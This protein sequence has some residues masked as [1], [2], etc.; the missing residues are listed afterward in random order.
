MGAL[1]C[2]DCTHAS[3]LCIFGVLNCSL[4]LSL[5]PLRSR[6][7]PETTAAIVLTGAEGG[8]E[9]EAAVAVCK[10]AEITTVVRQSVQQEPT[11][12]LKDGRVRFGEEE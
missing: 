10:E 2:A 11:G 8:E 1:R 12:Y 7:E 4:S 5:S 6:Y 3:G 9:E